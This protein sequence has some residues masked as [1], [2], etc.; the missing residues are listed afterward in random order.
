LLLGA[1]S[2]LSGVQVVWGNAMTDAGHVITEYESP[3]AITARCVC[4]WSH[5]ETRR[6]NALAR[7][8]KINAAKRKHL[9]EVSK[10]ES[11]R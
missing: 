9:A 6:Q 2:D 7:A 8:S 1:V 5:R 10:A 11:A 4:G 3:V